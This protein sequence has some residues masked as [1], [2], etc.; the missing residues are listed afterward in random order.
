MAMS[1]KVIVPPHPLIKHWL[2]I[3]RDKNTPNILYSTA[4][5]QIGRW[6]TYEALRDWLPYKKESIETYTGIADA[7]Y[8]D[9]DYPIRIIAQ[10]PEGLTLWYGS[11]E[12]I[13][14]ATLSLG[15]TPSIISKNEGIIIYSEQIMS[16][17]NPVATLKELENLGVESNRIL[18]ISS[19]CSDKGL[20]K[21]A[22]E[23]PNQVIYTSCIDNE[24]NTNNLLIPGIGNPIYRLS[25]MF[26]E[27]N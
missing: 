4:F 10:I 17:N 13:P 25:T 9:N 5:E 22:K 21:I 26:K 1:L 16:N 27:K 3:L 6:L 23:Y 20:N 14:N 18:L 8:I 7:V 15:K 11:K 2:S 24:D 19:I 12:V